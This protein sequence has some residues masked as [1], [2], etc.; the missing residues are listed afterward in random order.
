MLACH[1]SATGCHIVIDYRPFGFASLAFNS[2]AHYTISHNS[3]NLY[4][5]FLLIHSVLILAIN[6]LG[7]NARLPSYLAEAC[8]IQHA[9]CVYTCHI[10]KAVFESPPKRIRAGKNAGADHTGYVLP[11]RI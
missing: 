6:N 3:N 9:F 5:L 8:K 7:V 10:T 1:T 11:A 2:F 4:F